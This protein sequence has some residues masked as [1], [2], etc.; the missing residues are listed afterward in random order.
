MD[1]DVDDDAARLACRET[2]SVRPTPPRWHGE[3]WLFKPTRPSKTLPVWNRGLLDV[4]A[5]ACV[6]RPA[7]TIGAYAIDGQATSISPTGP[8]APK[9][10]GHST[11]EM[12]MFTW[13]HG[14]SPHVLWRDA[15]ADRSAVPRPRLGLIEP[16][17]PKAGKAR[18]PYP[19]EVM[20]RVYFLLQWCRAAL[21]NGL[22]DE[23]SE[24]ERDDGIDG[25][26][27]AEP[28]GNGALVSGGGHRW[29]GLSGAKRVQRHG[30]SPSA[31]IAI[32]RDRSMGL[33]LVV[34]MFSWH[35]AVYSTSPRRKTHWVR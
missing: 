15:G 13:R 29:L 5:R 2:M 28:S 1:A 34:T 19:L 10:R 20:L 35:G 27:S 33:D 31:A 8:T 7:N 3:E 25:G 32:R 6:A 22:I 11:K 30:A 21:A 18:R 26:V 14:L 16:H 23:H 9:R 17:D 12:T 24:A 4:H